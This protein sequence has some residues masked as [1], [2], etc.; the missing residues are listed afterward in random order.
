MSARRHV[1]ADEAEQELV[2]HRPL[3]D[4]LP[5]RVGDLAGRGAPAQV[6]RPQ[7]G[8]LQDRLDG[9]LDGLVAASRRS[10]QSGV[11]A[12]LRGGRAG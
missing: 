2:A 9:A 10:V 1:A 3:P 8:N 6:S 7:R 11:H 12:L 5:Q 4:R